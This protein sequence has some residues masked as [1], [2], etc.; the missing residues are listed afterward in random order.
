[1]V[2]VNWRFLRQPW[3]VVGLAC[4][5]GLTGCGSGEQPR[6]PVV[7]VSGKVL[8]DGQAPVQAEIRLRPDVPLPD[9]GKRSIEPYAIVKEDGTFLVGT[10]LT[11]DGAPLGEYSLFLV[12]PTITV[13]GVEEIVGPDRFKGQFNKPEYPLARVHVGQEKVVIPDLNLQAP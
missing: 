4:I 7:P 10:Y 12:W 1:M 11:D 6:L 13:D 3:L 2:S 9:P 5:F 8:I